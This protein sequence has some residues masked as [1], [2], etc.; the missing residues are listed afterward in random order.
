MI[1]A[2]KRLGKNAVG[3]IQKGAGCGM[4]DHPKEPDKYIVPKIFVAA[5]VPR[6]LMEKLIIVTLRCCYYSHP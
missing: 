5:G 2:L 6:N 4:L 1:I 3:G